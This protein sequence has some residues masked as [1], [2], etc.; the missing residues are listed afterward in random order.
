[1]G[2]TVAVH[3]PRLALRH[4][5]AVLVALAHHVDGPDIALLS[6][7]GEP[8]EG[9]VVVL[10]HTDALVVA[11]AQVALGPGVALL[12]RRPIELHSP[13]PILHHAGTHLIAEP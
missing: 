5:V 3:G 11:V 6:G 4:T 1:M 10:L 8:P 9:L 2:L 7:L 12:R 13:C